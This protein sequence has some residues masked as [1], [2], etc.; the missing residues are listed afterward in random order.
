[1]YHTKIWAPKANIV[2]ILYVT[3]ETLTGVCFLDRK[4]YEWWDNDLS[5]AKV[6]KYDK[7]THGKYVDIRPSFVHGPVIIPRQSFMTYLLCFLFL[8][9]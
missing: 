2:Y 5:K 9:K 8:F 6:E 7:Q 4:R 1:M 3:S